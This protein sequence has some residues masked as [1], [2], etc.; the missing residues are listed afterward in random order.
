ME[1]TILGYIREKILALPKGKLLPVSALSKA[2]I[3]K[4]PKLAG[5]SN[6]YARINKILA[7][8]EFVEKYEKKKG[9][10]KNDPK[11]GLPLT[12]IRRKT[13]ED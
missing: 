9:K 12:Y 7:E 10:P 1:P 5:G 13:Q 6:I 4:F 2:I 8:K 11:V 3:K